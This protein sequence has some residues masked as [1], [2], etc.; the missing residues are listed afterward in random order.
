MAA[1]GWAAVDEALEGI[2][3]LTSLNDFPYATCRA[4]RA[5]GQ[6]EMLLE[7]KEL[8]VWAVRYWARSASTLA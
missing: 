4:I 7:G 2:T 5:G 6:T 1:E 8:G 3:S